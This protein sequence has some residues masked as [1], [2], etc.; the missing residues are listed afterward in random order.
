MKNFI[1][2]LLGFTILGTA[3]AQYCTPVYT[4]G[5]DSYDNIGYIKIASSDD[6]TYL[7]EYY[8]TYVAGTT[9]TDKT[10]STSATDW[11]GATFGFA[12]PVNFNIAVNSAGGYDI[13][14]G[15]W[16][17]WND[18]EDFYDAGEEIAVNTI[19]TTF[20]FGYSDLYAVDNSVITA[21]VHRVRVRTSD[22]ITEDEMD[23]CSELGFGEAVDF[24]ISIIGKTYCDGNE[25]GFPN[26]YTAGIAINSYSLNGTEATVNM[27]NSGVTYIDQTVPSQSV[28]FTAE[29]GETVDLEFE[30]DADMAGANLMYMVYI[31]NNDNGTFDAGYEEI[32]SFSSTAL[33]VSEEITIPET[34]E[35]GEHTLRT[36]ITMYDEVDI[37]TLSPEPGI[38]M[39][40]AITITEAEVTSV[41]SA[42]ENNLLQVFPNPANDF[43]QCTM[44]EP[45]TGI[46]TLYDVKGNKVLET[47][48][49]HNTQP[50]DVSALP[51]GVYQLAVTSETGNRSTK[52]IQIQ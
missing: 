15:V 48:F 40:A 47:A 2:T 21:G 46:I 30:L 23:P 3:Q 17:D 16:V 19:E 7:T 4:Y 5:V 52:T 33:N 9:L 14:A 31:D 45:G 8:H 50:V 11:G 38:V 1:L 51:A 29:Q 35:P 39:D 26:Y 32:A 10:I 43:I 42:A 27:K 41:S 22:G 18:D 24:Y 49:T 36:R 28:E 44:A 37:C 34:L 13:I 12:H 25:M 20:G 6:F